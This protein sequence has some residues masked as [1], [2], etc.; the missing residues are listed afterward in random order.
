MSS[1][2]HRWG[3]TLNSVI[4]MLLKA[5]RGEKDKRLV[6]AKLGQTLCVFGFRINC[7]ING[8]MFAASGAAAVLPSR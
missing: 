7:T 2:G 3:H 6:T 4:F 1:L 8:W 5:V